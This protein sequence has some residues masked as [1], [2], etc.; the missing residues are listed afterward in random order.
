MVYQRDQAIKNF[1][2]EPYFELN[3]EILA[4]QQKFVAKLDPY[5][6]F[7]DETGLMTFMQAKHVQKGSQDGFIKDVQKQGKKRASPQ[8]FSLSS[9]QSA[10]NK[11][12]HAS[13]SQTL[14]AIQSLYEAK[15]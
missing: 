5:Q 3:A 4:N 2:P 13:A 14:A 9:L 8:L 12:Y 10:M 11:R 15:L 1:K 7:K 6:R